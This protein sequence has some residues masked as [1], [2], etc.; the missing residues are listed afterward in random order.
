MGKFPFDQR[1]VVCGVM[2]KTTSVIQGY[3][4]TRPHYCLLCLKDVENDICKV[5]W[6]S[7]RPFLTSF[8]CK[9]RSRFR[10]F[11]N[12]LL[13]SPLHPRPSAVGRKHPPLTYTGAQQEMNTPDSLY[14]QTP[15]GTNTV[16]FS[17]HKYR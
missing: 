12:S 17:P 6:P 16:P 5:Q 11:L 8:L 15:Q 14:S 2:S 10:C 4:M 9:L 7:H 13:F 3:T 1:S